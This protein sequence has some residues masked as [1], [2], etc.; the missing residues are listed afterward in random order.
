[1]CSLTDR[2]ALLENILRERGIDFPPTSHPPKSRHEVRDI[3]D[4]SSNRTATEL[5]PQDND[6]S[7]PGSQSVMHEEHL[8]FNS[9]ESRKISLSK[10]DGVGLP[11]VLSDPKSEDMVSKLLSTQGY[12]SFDRLNR[13]LRFFGPTTNCDVYSKSGVP[14]TSISQTSSTETHRASRII[15]SL[16]LETHDYLMDLFWFCYNPVIRVLSRD[17]FLEDQKKG[18]TQF[19]SP[20]LHACILAMGYRFANKE[21]AEIKKIA[22]LDFGSTLHREARQLLSH[23]LENPGGIPSIVALLL[24]GDLEGG[25]EYVLSWS[26]I[27]TKIEQLAETT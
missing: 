7:S 23:E 15:T 12:F 24:L 1:M 13:P 5:Q 16:P 10:V 20:F 14:H 22:L 11:P 3:R 2:V 8:D 21:N 19:Y 9:S 27:Y 6:G 17:A 25:S 18:G 26:E 4:T